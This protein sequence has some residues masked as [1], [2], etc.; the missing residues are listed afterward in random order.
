MWLP[1]KKGLSTFFS[2]RL[3]PN[4]AQLPFY[5]VSKIFYPTFCSFFE[6]FQVP[7]VW[8]GGTF[9]ER[10]VW[11]KN[12]TKWNLWNQLMSPKIE[13][14]ILANMNMKSDEENLY[15]LVQ[16]MERKIQMIRKLGIK[17]WV[18]FVTS[19]RCN[20]LVVKKKTKVSSKMLYQLKGLKWWLQSICVCLFCQVRS[21]SWCKSRRL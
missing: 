6:I 17:I 1:N 19:E 10:E 21:V 13:K 18:G 14:N 7:N 16:S 9:P 15:L 5:Q 3:N 2:P 4:P 12:F 8:R 20:R 11:K